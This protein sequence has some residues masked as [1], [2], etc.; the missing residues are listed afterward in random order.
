MLLNPKG[1][2]ASQGK[3]AGVVGTYYSPGA[4]T[5]AFYWTPDGIGHMTE[6]PGSTAGPIPAGPSDRVPTWSGIGDPAYMVGPPGYFGTVY[7]CD[8]I[9]MYNRGTCE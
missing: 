6:V 5:G 7:G 8:A 2:Y 1:K 3:Q 9:I 4:S